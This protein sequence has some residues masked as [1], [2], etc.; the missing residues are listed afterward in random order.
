[1][2][3]LIPLKTRPTLTY[4]WLTYF[5]YYYYYWYWPKEDVEVRVA[6]HSRRI[7]PSSSIRHCL[8]R[9][10]DTAKY[11][12]SLEPDLADDVDSHFEF[13]SSFPRLRPWYCKGAVLDFSYD[14]LST[15]MLASCLKCARMPN[16]I[17]MTT[18]WLLS[19]AIVKK[20]SI[21]MNQL[22]SPIHVKLRAKSSNAQHIAYFCFCRT[23]HG[24]E[25]KSN[26][27]TAC[28]N[29]QLCVRACVCA[30]C[31]PT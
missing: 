30:R 10:T 7:K 4:Q 6:C 19:I 18:Y 12:C 26:D 16:L 25:N 8:S 24:W 13:P 27:F 3:L 15:W 11:T 28:Q 23:K 22:D 17:I 2:W 31:I 21:A 1:M 14:S 29:K 5:Y 9:P 20:S